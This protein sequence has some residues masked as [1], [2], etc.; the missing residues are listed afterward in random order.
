MP[1]TSTSSS[2]GPTRSTSCARASAIRP[3]SSTPI[4]TTRSTSRTP[5]SYPAELHE[6]FASPLYAFAFVL[7]VLAFMGQAQ[8]TRTN[9]MQAVIAAFAVAVLSRILGITCANAVVVRPAAA[10]LLYAVPAGA[11]LLAA[12]AIQW[13]MYP[14]PPSRAARAA[15]AFLELMGT[16]L[17]ALWPRRRAPT[18]SGIGA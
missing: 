12:V 2:S 5:G 13:H 16:G 9:R 6:R 7:L 8:T 4:P 3:S 1:W 10:P 14:R 15:R 17:A 11:A 18:P